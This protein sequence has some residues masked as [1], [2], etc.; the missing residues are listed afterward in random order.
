[1]RAMAVAPATLA[2]SGAFALIGA[3]RDIA[4]LAELFCLGAAE[5]LATWN[6]SRDV[7]DAPL[8]DL[9]RALGQSSLPICHCPT[10]AIF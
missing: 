7:A 3:D 10:G 6:P 8:R 4:A 5:D 9:S 2:G 1:M